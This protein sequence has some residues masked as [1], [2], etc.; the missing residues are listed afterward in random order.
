M[1][2]ILAQL[3]DPSQHL[4]WLGSRALGIVA[5]LLVSVS[6]GFGLALSVRIG[7]KPGMPARLKTLHEAVA[8]VS[9]IAIGGH[10]LLLLGDSY[11]HPSIAQVAIPFL[12]PNRTSWTGLGVIAGWLAM[13]L[14]LSF[15]VRK[16]IGVKLWRKLHRWTILVFILGLVHTIGSGTDGHSAWLI[17]MLALVAAPVALIGSLRVLPREQR[18]NR[19][20]AHALS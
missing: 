4:F 8:L 1:G 6:V 15:Y 5:M 12:L 16:R 19:G 2:V 14:G 3:A 20:A 18:G 7:G 9:L 17:A 13:V 11:L 10:G